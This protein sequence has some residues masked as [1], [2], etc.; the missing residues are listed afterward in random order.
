MSTTAQDFYTLFCNHKFRKISEI[1]Q[2]GFS[3]MY[4]VLKLLADAKR[5]LTAGDISESF[6]V[7]TAR[8]AVIL[9]TLEKKEYIEK[10]KSKNDGRQTIVKITQKGISVLKERKKKLFETINTYLSKLKP[11]EIDDLY[12]IIKT[13]LS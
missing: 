10:S 13:L 7:T 2:E 6:G 8:T 1:I 3:G 12:G 4:Y 11:T 9:N 5:E